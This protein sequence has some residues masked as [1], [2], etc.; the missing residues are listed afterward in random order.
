M[1]DVTAVAVLD[2]RTRPTLAVTPT[3]D[4]TTTA[5]VGVSSGGSTGSHEAT[6][7]LTVLERH[8]E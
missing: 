7:G 4:H 1:T 2:S 8:G 6:E 5:R 3:L